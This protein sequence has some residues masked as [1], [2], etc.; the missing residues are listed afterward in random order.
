MNRRGKKRAWKAKTWAKKGR[1]QSRE[2][3]REAL[4]IIEEDPAGW[5]W[6]M[7]KEVYD[8][9]WRVLWRG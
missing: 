1:N 3:I 7:G 6:K 9:K 4:I 8:T 5:G 2:K